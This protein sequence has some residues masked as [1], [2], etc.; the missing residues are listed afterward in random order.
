MFADGS[1]GVRSI[2]WLLQCSHLMVP[3]CIVVCPIGARLTAVTGG[4]TIGPYADSLPLSSQFQGGGG[5]VW[6]GGLKG[7]GAPGPQHIWLKMTP[8]SR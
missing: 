6:G 3:L 1:L 4:R 2:W 8:S 5:W 7:R